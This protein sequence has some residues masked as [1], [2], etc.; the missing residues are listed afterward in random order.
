VAIDVASF[1]SAFPEFAQ[2]PDQ[3]VQEKLTS[4]IR[5]TDQ[6]V[7]GSQYEDGVFFRTADLLAKCP[8]GRK[9]QLVNK[10]GSTAYSA[11]LERLERIA[12]SGYRVF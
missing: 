9:M 7:W 11:D 5:Q 1:K 8:Y 2:A 3:T 12:A 6:G 4:A 10:D